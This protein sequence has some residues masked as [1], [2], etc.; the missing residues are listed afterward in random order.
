MKKRN[1]KKDSIFLLFLFLLV[2]L[3]IFYDEIRVDLLL[4]TGYPTFLRQSGEND[5]DVIND[6]IPYYQEKDRYSGKDLDT[7]Y[8]ILWIKKEYSKYSYLSEQQRHIFIDKVSKYEPRNLWE[9]YLQINLLKYKLGLNNFEELNNYLSKK[10]QVCEKDN[11]FLNT[12]DWNDL[13]EVGVYFDI[14]HFCKL[15]FS[16]NDVIRLEQVLSKSKEYE[17]IKHVKEHGVNDVLVYVNN[18]TLAMDSNEIYHC[19]FF[20]RYNVVK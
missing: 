7:L 9:K 8:K 11:L 3:I 13:F 10:I 20:N 16:E 2:F 17:L 1:Y 15:N 4:L 6:K 12:V 18:C 19:L 5:L 14:V